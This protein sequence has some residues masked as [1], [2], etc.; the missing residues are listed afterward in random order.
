VIDTVN[1]SE[2]YRRRLRGTSILDSIHHRPIPGPSFPY[3]VF[4]IW[5]F[6]S[7]NGW[8]SDTAA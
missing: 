1:I 7:E 5:G 4:W 2:D 6:L 8:V 3:E